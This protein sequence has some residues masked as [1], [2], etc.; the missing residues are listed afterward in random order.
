LVLFFFPFSAP[1]PPHQLLIEIN[2]TAPARNFS[3]H[4]AFGS[5]IVSLNFSLFSPFFPFFPLDNR[6]LLAH[7]TFWVMLRLLPGNANLL[8]GVSVFA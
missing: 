1:I 6:L 2:A 7:N 8:I 4:L 3:T 5:S